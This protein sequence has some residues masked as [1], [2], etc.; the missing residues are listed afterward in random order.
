MRDHIDGF[1]QLVQ[2][3]A[4]RPEAF[5]TETIQHGRTGIKHMVF[6]FEGGTGSARF[7]LLLDQ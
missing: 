2:D 3:E 6:A 1:F 7:I 5:F 4:E